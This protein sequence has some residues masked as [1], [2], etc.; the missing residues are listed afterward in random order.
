MKHF[1]QILVTSLLLLAPSLSFPI[2][3]AIEIEQSGTVSWIVDGDTFDINNGAQRIRPADIDAPERNEIGYNSSKWYLKD[4]IFS[5][6]IYLDVSTLN[7]VDDGGRLICLVYLDYNSTHYLN[8]NKQIA[9]SGHALIKDYTNDF[10]PYTW[11]LYTPKASSAQTYTLTDQY[12]EGSGTTDPVSATYTYPKVATVKITAKPSE[13]WAFD[14]WILNGVNAGNTNPYTIL[15]D[16]NQTLKAS[17]RQV[18][19]NPPPAPKYVLIILSSEGQ[20]DVKPTSGSYTY[21][22]VVAVDVSASPIESWIFDRW[23]IDGLVNVSVNPYSINMNANH[24]L[25]AVFKPQIKAWVLTVNKNGS[26]TVKPDVG[27]STINEGLN[28]LLTAKA[29]SGWV[30]DFWELDG[31]KV[32]ANSNYIIVMNSDHKITA[33]FKQA[34]TQ[35]PGGGVPG[36]SIEASLIG[37]FAVIGILLHKYNHRRIYPLA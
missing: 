18:N 35:N 30:F 34:N 33:S 12:P 21:N 27:V 22:Q 26:G 24:T 23:I 25:K 13:G 20:G 8:V 19:S 3:N 4:L 1:I 9:Q 29:E 10:N 14:H 7:G 17:Y 28:V 31:S 36:Y 6:T 32:S 5:K 15:I 16:R 2:T 11:T 37:L